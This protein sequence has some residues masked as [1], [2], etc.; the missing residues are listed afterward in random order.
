MKKIE[1]KSF[2]IKE[3]NFNE[4]NKELIIE[5]YAATFN[6]K[7]YPQVTWNNDLRDYVMA[8]DTIKKGA[9]EKTLSERKSRVAFCKNHDIYDAKGKI[10]EL[11][12]DETG[13]FI[14]VRISDAETELK[15][16]IRED[17]YK[18]FSIGFQTIKSE[19]K[20]DDE[21]D[22]EKVYVRELQEIKLFEVSIVTIARDE[23]SVITDIKSMVDAGNLIDTLIE[24]EKV[25]EKKYKL[26][27]LK[28]LMTN[29]PI[30]SL[31]NN[32]PKTLDI[33]KLTLI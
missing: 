25:E 19:F 1:Y 22:N 30:Q 32:K 2:E 18:E 4:E 3:I 16:K 14:K 11:K 23:N 29:E 24:N 33:N 13:L 21:A 10:L 15:T 5:G 6:N 31:E 7:D 8:S 12:E 20:K 26:L 17:I 27:Q 28:S 9:F